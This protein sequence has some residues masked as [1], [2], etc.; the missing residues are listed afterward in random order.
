MADVVKI[1]KQTVSSALAA[2]H[3]AAGQLKSE[4]ET[5]AGAALDAFNAH[6]AA[7]GDD[8]AGHE[9]KKAIQPEEVHELLGP[10]QF[11]D[12]A[13]LNGNAVTRAVE[14]LGVNTQTAIER[15]LA[16]DFL[17]GQEMKKPQEKV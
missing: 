7:A 16:S 12:G 10:A 13:P 9:Y 15:S 6:I 4:F 8:H 2:W 14:A 3:D 17:Q 1:E 11:V 5:K